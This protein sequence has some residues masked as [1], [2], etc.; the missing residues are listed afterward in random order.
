[1]VILYYA[2]CLV[3]I[4]TGQKAENLL[5]SEVNMELCVTWMVLF[6]PG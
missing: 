3:R 4:I 2:L 5:S 1:M 6:D